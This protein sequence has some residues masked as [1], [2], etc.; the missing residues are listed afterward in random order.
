MQYR[1]A[2][3]FLTVRNEKRIVNR[4]IFKVR[5]KAPYNEIQVIYRIR[6]KIRHATRE[7]IINI[8]M[9]KPY[10]E[11]KKEL[12]E[13]FSRHFDVPERHINLKWLDRVPMIRDVINFEWKIKT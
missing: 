4:V 3:E 12:L 8:N 5:F 11:V 6:S 2:V 1:L 7:N 13:E 9:L 10:E